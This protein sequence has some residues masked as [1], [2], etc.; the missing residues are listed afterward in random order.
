VIRDG[1][2]TGQIP[3][4]WING[5]NSLPLYESKG[6]RR[7]CKKLPWYDTIAYDLDLRALKT[8]GRANLI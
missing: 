5:I 7:E 1:W 3:H 6:G 8:D 4:D 2:E